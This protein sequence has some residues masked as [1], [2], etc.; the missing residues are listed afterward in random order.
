MILSWYDDFTWPIYI[1]LNAVNPGDFVEMGCRVCFVDRGFRS[2]VKLWVLRLR[3]LL[4]ISISS[5]VKDF[6]LYGISLVFAFLRM[7]YI[8]EWQVVV[9]MLGGFI[10]SA[11]LKLDRFRFNANIIFVTSE[12]IYFIIRRLASFSHGWLV[13]L[14]WQNVVGSQWPVRLK[15]IT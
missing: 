4:I 14:G 9:M 11:Y 15:M 3:R 13:E 12:L 1:F 6:C 2:T 7:A 5:L 10:S 8:S